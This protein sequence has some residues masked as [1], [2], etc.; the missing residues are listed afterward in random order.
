MKL[1]LLIAVFVPATAAAQASG[2]PSLDNPTA[3]SIAIFSEAI[4]GKG[5]PAWRNERSVTDESVSVRRPSRKDRWTRL[6]EARIKANQ[7]AAKRS[8]SY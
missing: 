7:R 8:V 4:R 3:G 6:R 1:L 2:T 5:D